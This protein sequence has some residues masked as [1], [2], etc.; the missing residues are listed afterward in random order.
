MYNHYI[1]RFSF[2]IAALILLAT[3]VTASDQ[4]MNQ[5]AATNITGRLIPNFSMNFSFST[6]FQFS[7][8]KGSVG[9][10]NANT[11]ISQY[12]SP[13]LNELILRKRSFED[14]HIA[15]GAS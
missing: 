4:N 15:L 14:E 3:K 9:E 6:A 8:G 5:N 7:F 13:S 11:N 10:K 12:L 2:L 1:K